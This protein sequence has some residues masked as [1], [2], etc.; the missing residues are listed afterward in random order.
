MRLMRRHK[1]KRNYCLSDPSPGSGAS[2][3]LRLVLVNILLVFT[4]R[5][6]CHVGAQNKREKKSSGNLTQLLCQTWAKFVLNLHCLSAILFLLNFFRSLGWNLARPKT[7]YLRGNEQLTDRC[8]TG[9]E[10]RQLGVWWLWNWTA[11]ALDFWSQINNITER[12]WRSAM[13]NADW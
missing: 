9:E 11:H 5:H 10:I 13:G 7:L 3:S 6:R 8:T 1:W 2:F 4:W 12:D